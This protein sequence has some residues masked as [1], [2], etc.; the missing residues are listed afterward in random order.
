MTHALRLHILGS[1]SKGNCELIEGPEGII[2][3][4]NGF[5]RREV[6]RRMAELELEASRVVALIVTHEHSD[7]VKGLPV[8][9]EL[10]GR[11]A[12]KLRHPASARN[13]RGASVYGVRAGGMPRHRGDRGADVFY[14]A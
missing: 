4:D 11:V 3:V 8:V 12:R 9:Q 14:L 2:M 5:S 10:P 13:A 6:L 1:G 7:H